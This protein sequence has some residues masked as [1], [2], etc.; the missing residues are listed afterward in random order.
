MFDFY[1]LITRQ[2]Y[3]T[4][5]GYD[6]LY[7]IVL[8]RL[9]VSLY[10]IVDADTLYD[11]NGGIGAGGTLIQRQQVSAYS[12]EWVI[13]KGDLKDLVK[14]WVRNPLANKGESSNFI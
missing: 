10:K 6:Q 7:E 1:K 13:F 12:S 5:L 3:C 9:Q 4:F 14:E 2:C 8:F 11:S